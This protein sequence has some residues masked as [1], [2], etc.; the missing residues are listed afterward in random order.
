MKNKST[1][2][3]SKHQPTYHKKYNTKAEAHKI[4]FKRRNGAVDNYVAEI[5]YIVVHRVATDNI[6]DKHKNRIASLYQIKLIKNGGHIH[7]HCKHDAVQ[8]N[9]I[10]EENGESAQKQAH[11]A[12]K[13]KTVENCQGR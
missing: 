9:N 8:M 10:S 2:R 7:P 13:Q 5:G 4:F 11:S 12:Y 6:A 1:L 3:F